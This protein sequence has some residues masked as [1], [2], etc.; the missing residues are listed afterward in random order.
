[1]YWKNICDDNYE[2]AAQLLRQIDIFQKYIFDNHVEL[3]NL[4]GWLCR[5]YYSYKDIHG[6][7]TAC[8]YNEKILINISFDPDMP[9]S[10]GN[11]IIK[12]LKK[13]LNNTD[14]AVRI[15]CRYQN[16]NLISL[17][18]KRFSIS[19]TSHTETRDK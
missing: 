19:P 5:Y 8:I 12:I 9:V 18:S 11:E 7:I 1:M 13:L 2:R 4:G 14:K 15:W 17:I 6:V 10:T 3:D 16:K